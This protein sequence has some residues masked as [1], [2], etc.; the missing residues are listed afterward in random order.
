MKI[1]EFKASDHWLENFK[2]RHAIKFR[3]EQGEAAEVDLEEVENWQETVLRDALAK[4]SANDV[5]NADETG[6][7]WRLMPNKTLTFKSKIFNLILIKLFLDEKC[8]GGKKSKERVTVLVGANASGTEKLPLFV[9]G[10]SK[11]PRCFK[12]ANVPVKYAANSKAWMTA[13]LFENWLKTWNKKLKSDNRKVLLILDN[14]SGHPKVNLSNIEL[15]FLPPN[16]TSISQV[17][18][19]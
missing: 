19:I 5:F 11:K 1:E 9:I 8:V 7:F 13:E 2:I 15:K 10:K 4:Y 18:F 3:S 6:L 17:S 12:N 16:T 14:F